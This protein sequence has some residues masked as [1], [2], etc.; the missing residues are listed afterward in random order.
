[1]NKIKKEE[2]DSQK[3]NLKEDN[4]KLVALTHD[5][6]ARIEAIISCDSKYLRSRDKDAEPNGNYPGS[7]AFW[8]TE[9]KKHLL[10]KRKKGQYTYDKVIF[11]AVSAVDRENSTHINADGVGR[12]EL[13]KRILSITQEE[14]FDVLKNHELGFAFIETLSQKTHPLEKGKKARCNY[15]FA[16]KFLHYA[17]MYV[18]EG[19]NEQD[20]Y[21]IYD[22]V[23]SSVLPMYIDKYLQKKVRK[24]YFLNY[25]DYI[26]VI[27]EIIAKAGGKISRNGFDHILWYYYKGKLD[28]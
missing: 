10:N 15:S 13:S 25:P 6:V 5:N 3:Y 4:F 14:L 19:K 21:S 20:N 17:C 18:F 2:E 11:E 22:N 16:T 27:D 24:S 12:D 28:Q 9:L 26:K 7:T 8:M 1:M 23:V